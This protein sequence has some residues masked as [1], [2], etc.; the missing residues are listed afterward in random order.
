[1][2]FARSIVLSGPMGVGKSTVARALAEKT[3]VPLV[4]VD[5]ALEAAAGKPVAQLF[6]DEGEATFRAREARE[7][8]RLL[9]DGVP[10]V[11]ALGGGAVL[12][13]ATRRA[14]LHRAIVVTLGAPPETLV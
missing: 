11:L 10:R 2:T 6:A 1:M 14:L 8:A 13:D 3:G 4:D 5:A 12:H 7:I 9:D